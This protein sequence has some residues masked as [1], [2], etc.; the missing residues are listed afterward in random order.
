MARTHA[1]LLTRIWSDPEFVALDAGAQRIYILALSQPNL[2]YCGVV[3]YTARRWATFARDTTVA[4]VTKAVK[5]L[6]TASF[7]LLD[8]DTEEL[9]IRSFV[10]HDGVLRSPNLVVAMSRDF[11]RI[12]SKGLREGFL[13][14]FP[15]GFLEGLDER[16]RQG[17][18]EGFRQGFRDALGRGS[19]VRSAEPPPPPHVSLASTS[20][21]RPAVANGRREGETQVNGNGD[22]LVERIVARLGG[23]ARHRMEAQGLVSTWRG[24]LDARLIDQA[25]G[26]CEQAADKPRS[27]AY[28]DQALRNTAAQYGVAED[29]MPAGSSGG[30]A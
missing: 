14:G 4:M 18:A 10:K 1:R 22:P 30:R 8:E 5:A 11:E 23:S 21:S 20:D 12:S 6:V 13:K 29:L 7:V 15:E 17:L 16:V 27:V 24:V 28:F 3:P 26:L 19:R 25:I 9:M 2:S